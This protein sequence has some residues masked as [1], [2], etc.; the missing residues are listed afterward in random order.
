M[1][2][3]RAIPSAVGLG[4]A[5][6]DSSAPV[7]SQDVAAPAALP[8]DSDGGDTVQVVDQTNIDLDGSQD[9]ATDDAN[10][11]ATSGDDASQDDPADDS[12]DLAAVSVDPTQDASSDDS[13]DPSSG[14]V[15]PALQSPPGS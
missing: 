10:L 4:S 9:P 3:G 8:D 7:A 6:P 13:A 11:P 1:L 14:D 2:E 15:D 12:D 5:P